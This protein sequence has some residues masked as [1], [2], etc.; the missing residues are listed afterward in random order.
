[1]K[2][3]VKEQKALETALPIK[4]DR[5]ISSQFLRAAMTADD[6]GKPM[7]MMPTR[8]RRSVEPPSF[9]DC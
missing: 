7:K 3:C 4:F 2:K 9:A 5:L 6:M 8:D 1:M